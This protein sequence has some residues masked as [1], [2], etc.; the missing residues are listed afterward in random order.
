MNK[1]Y[2]EDLQTKKNSLNLLFKPA[3]DPTFRRLTTNYTNLNPKNEETHKKQTFKQKKQNSPKDAPNRSQPPLSAG[4][5]PLFALAHSVSWCDQAPRSRKAAVQRLLE[6]RFV[7]WG[8]K[9]DGKW[10]VGLVGGVEG[11]L[12]V[13][14][15]GF[16]GGFGV[17]WWF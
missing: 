13:F 10:L 12:I 5:T 16:C 15:E 17:V 3:K 4:E 6:G 14:F 11:G 2:W 8:K 7:G 1:N 9:G